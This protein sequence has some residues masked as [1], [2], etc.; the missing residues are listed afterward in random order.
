MQAHQ[1]FSKGQWIGAFGATFVAAY[2]AFALGNGSPLRKLVS[3]TLMAALF[4]A[5]SFISQ[6]FKQ[7]L[8]FTDYR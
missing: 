3:P 7:K 8:E 6:R 1:A 2:A 5:M 4:G